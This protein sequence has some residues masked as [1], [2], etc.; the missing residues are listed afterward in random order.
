MRVWLAPRAAS[1][2]LDFG[3]PPPCRARL[4]Q[5][6]LARDSG[7][8]FCGGHPAERVRRRRSITG[9]ASARRLVGR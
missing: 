1:A 2:R 3:S 8:G 5:P 6:S 4:E 9:T 7:D